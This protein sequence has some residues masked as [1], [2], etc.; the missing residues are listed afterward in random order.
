MSLQCNS[1]EASRHSDVPHR[2]ADLCL[3][4]GGQG[5]FPL[6]NSPVGIL[7]IFGSFVLFCNMN[8][9]RT[10]LCFC[11]AVYLLHSVDCSGHMISPS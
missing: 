8:P 9:C 3:W 7:T 11:A 1:S 4:G 10:K 2:P 5:R 6:S